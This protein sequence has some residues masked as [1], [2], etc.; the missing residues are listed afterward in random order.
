M[1]HQFK[2][3][4]RLLCGKI[5]HVRLHL[6]GLLLEGCEINFLFALLGKIDNVL[7]VLE[8]DLL[9]A[10]FFPL[11]L[12]ED[13]YVLHSKLLKDGLHFRH[14]PRVTILE[15][16]LI[17]VSGERTNRESGYMPEEQELPQ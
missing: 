8:E 3:Y 9:F 13:G 6:E 4:S 14:K 2:F 17:G 7:L 11:V 15:L 10:I 1:R 12:G 5:L 16:R